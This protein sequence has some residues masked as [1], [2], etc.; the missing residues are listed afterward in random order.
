MFRLRLLWFLL[1]YVVCSYCGRDFTA[2]GRHQWRCKKRMPINYGPNAKINTTIVDENDAAHIVETVK[3]CC[4]KSC[5]GVKGLKMHQRRCRILEGL[6]EDQLGFKNSNFDTN[7]SLD[8]NH[9]IYHIDSTF[10]MVQLFKQSL[11]II[12]RRQ[13]INGQWQMTSSSLF[14]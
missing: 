11:E 7:S 13:T 9:E 14:S 3:C 5:K 6:S 8:D 4:G 2:L 10:I 12:Y 1:F